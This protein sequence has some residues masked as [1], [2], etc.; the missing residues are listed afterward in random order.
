[1][2]LKGALGLSHVRDRSLRGRRVRRRLADGPDL[3]QLQ[4]HKCVRSRLRCTS[5][6]SSSDATASASASSSK[7]ASPA[8]YIVT[9]SQGT[10]AAAQSSAI[11][12]AGATDKGAI[13]PLAMHTVAVPAASGH[14]V[15]AALRANPS[16]ASVARNDSR[17]TEGTPNDPGYPDQWNLPITGWDQAYGSANP[18]GSS[19]IAVLDTGVSG[20]TGDLN[21]GTGWSA[22][23]TDPTIDPNGHGTAV[24][25]IAAATANNGTGIA[26]VDFAAPTILPVQVL[27]SDG[28]GQ[29][30]DIIQG[31]VWAAD[32][33][34]N[35]IL[36]S[37]SNPATAR[38]CR[39]RSATR[40]TRARSSWPRPAT[41]DRPIR[42]TRRATPT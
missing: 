27:G 29:D 39:T 20:S 36:M 16:V 10:S 28:L 21:L 14:A 12:A 23:G 26:G 30:S 17:K 8:P 6:P 34:A 1:M 4:R 24:A 7:I 33:G 40:G 2:A 11:A 3:E 13:A 42:P 15:V 32:H 37:F 31:V 19:T 38:R 18:L 5:T 35:V 22:F 9:F 25:S 41:A